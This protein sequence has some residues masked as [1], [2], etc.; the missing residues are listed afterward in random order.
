MNKN[1]KKLIRIITFITASLVAVIL[2]AN[3]LI[4]NEKENSNKRK[5]TKMV[6]IYSNYNWNN[7]EATFILNE[8]MTCKYPN[9]LQECTW[10]LTN[11]KILL[12][13]YGYEIQ[14]DNA[15]EN[16]TKMLRFDSKE[17]CESSLLDYT[18]IV[19]EYNL[20]N[21][22]CEHYIGDE[23]T[24]LK[25]VDNGILIHNHVFNKIE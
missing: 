12:T 5:I 22:H 13:F 25:I 8:D 19:K 16:I 17:I 18:G 6:G 24:E 2:V 9:S 4:K 11:D 21:P 20:V 23:K 3:Y 7:H 15:D 10:E 1:S 14:S